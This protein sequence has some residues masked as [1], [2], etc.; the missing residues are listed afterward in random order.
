MSTTLVKDLQ[1][2]D[3]VATRIRRKQ[4][5][6]TYVLF[7]LAVIV[8]LVIFVATRPSDF[9][10]T[11]SATMSAAPAA[12]FAQVNDFHN[13]EA[14]SPWAKLDPHAKTSFEGPSSG[15]GAIFRWNGDKNVGEGSMTI[16]DSRPH[17]FIGIRLDFVRPF[18]GT[19]DVQ[20]TFQPEGDRAAV[21]WSI[22]GKNNF[23]AKAVGLF[24]DCEKMTGDMFEQG[25]A[26]MKSVVESA[27]Q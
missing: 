17:E 24:M 12:V 25:L 21:T 11:R 5:M 4:S 2:D 9:R 16:T 15:T 8:L 23:L 10:V 7:A 6:L 18:A 26:S 19:N 22:A 20:F 13:W 1:A 27:N 3:P 14:W